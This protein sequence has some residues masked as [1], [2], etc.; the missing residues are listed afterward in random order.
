MVLFYVRDRRA[1]WDL[2]S[3]IT[4]GITIYSLLTTGLLRQLWASYHLCF[5]SEMEIGFFCLIGKTKINI[6]KLPE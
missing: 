3:R 6:Y 2:G 1:Q 5:S 4:E